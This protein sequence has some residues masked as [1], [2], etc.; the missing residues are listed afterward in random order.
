MG[1]WKSQKSIIGIIAIGLGL[2]AVVF[3]LIG[4]PRLLAKSESAEFCVQ[5]HVME[6][7]YEA[8][9]HAGAHRRN[10]CV[11]CHLP[12]DNSAV[13]YTWKTLDGLKDLVMF[14]TGSVSDS[15]RVT[16][17]GKSVLQENCVRCHETTVMLIDTERN[18]WACHR[19]ITH[20]RTG[21][22]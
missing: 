7:Q 15:I 3:L 18:C 21:A 10:N 17:H 6:S 8:W 11:D 14:Y 12:N 13:H 1:N 9:S 19:N 16:A 20:T 5:C 22:F 2:V 4:P